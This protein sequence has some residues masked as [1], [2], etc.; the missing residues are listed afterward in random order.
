MNHMAKLKS[1]SLQEKVL[2]ESNRKLASKSKTAQK[3]LF[4]TFKS[5]FV[6]KNDLSL[7]I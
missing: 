6:L 3:D 1:L 7:D 2:S 4:S 5:C